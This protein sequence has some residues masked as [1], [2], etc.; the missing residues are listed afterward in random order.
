MVLSVSSG[1]SVRIFATCAATIVLVAAC[2][3]PRTPPPLQPDAELAA[4]LEKRKA[5]KAFYQSAENMTAAQVDALEASLDRTPEDFDALRKLRHFYQ[6]SGQKV[7]GWNEMVARRRPHILWMIEQHPEHELA[8]WPVSADADPAGYRAAAQRWLAQAAKPDASE[9]VLVNAARF[10]AR[11]DRPIAE[12][13]LLRARAAITAPDR[14]RAL[15]SRLGHLYADVIKGPTDP[16]NGAPL[17]RLDADTYARDVRRRL[18]ESDD[19]AVLAAAG[20][21]LAH[22]F[23]DADRQ[24]LGV[25]LLQRAVQIDPQQQRA[26]ALL[27]AFENHDRN[28]LLTDKVRLRAAALAGGDIAAKVAARQ[29]L[30]PGEREKLRDARPQAVS[31]LSEAERFAL[32]PQLAGSDYMLAESSDWNKDRPGAAPPRRSAR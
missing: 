12:Q 10:F 19:A 5:D 31:E 29:L 26:R 27:V 4:Q 13:L 1:R 6:V 20:D 25:Q 22:T 23:G 7:F 8:M 11:T 21:T 28:Q 30:T 17:A 32:L 15:S 24:R 9:T 3:Q 16:G 2:R 14:Q 18:T